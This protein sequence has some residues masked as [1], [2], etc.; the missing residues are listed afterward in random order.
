MDTK[1]R[2][3]ELEIFLGQNQ[4]VITQLLLGFYQTYELDLKVNTLH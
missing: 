1:L 2:L 3:R 4:P